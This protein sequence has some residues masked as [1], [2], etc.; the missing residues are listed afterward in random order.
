MSRHYLPIPITKEL[1][2]ALTTKFDITEFPETH[3]MAWGLDSPT[4]G[5]FLQIW[6]EDEHNDYYLEDGLVGGSKN[7]IIEKLER[8][9]LIAHIKSVSS[10]HFG[11]LCLDLPF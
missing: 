6:H 9:G 11:M 3:N 5:Y 10:E 1:K 4:G 2:K 7:R 8:Y